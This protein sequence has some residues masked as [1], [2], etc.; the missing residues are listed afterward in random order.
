MSS[1]VRII[2]QHP[3]YGPCIGGMAHK[4]IE[5]SWH[6]KYRL[7]QPEKLAPLNYAAWPHWKK[8][9]W[10]AKY[11]GTWAINVYRE[12]REAKI[13]RSLYGRKRVALH[14]GIPKLRKKYK[15]PIEPKKPKVKMNDYK[16]KAIDPAAYGVAA[17]LNRAF[18]IGIVPP[19]NA[20]PIPIDGQALEQ[21]AVWYAAPAHQN[22]AFANGIVAGQQAQLGAIIPVAKPRNWLLDDEP[23]FYDE[24]R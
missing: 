23:P 13:R 3:N 15:K 1:R 5:E 12:P 11:E 18:K 21:A 6:R 19:P 9:L 2:A 7:S 14:L 24:E 16:F 10:M 4:Y 8:L 22:I 17:E 20:A